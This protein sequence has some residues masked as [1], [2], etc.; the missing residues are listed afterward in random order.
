MR[1]ARRFNWPLVVICLSPQLMASSGENCFRLN[2]ADSRR[3]TEARMSSRFRSFRL[4]KDRSNILKSR[5]WEKNTFAG[6]AMLA[7]MKISTQVHKTCN[8]F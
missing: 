2:F 4:E 6:W 3:A 1:S 5:A 7:K 8:I